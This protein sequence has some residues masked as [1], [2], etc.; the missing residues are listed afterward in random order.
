MAGIARE[1]RPFRIWDEGEKRDLP[2]RSYLTYER[3]VERALT[4]LV[5][6]PIG[7]SYTIYDSRNAR[8]LRQWKRVV[9]GLRE[10]A[11]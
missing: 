2:W 1:K 5:W 6:L 7:N 11:E 10:Y 3:A 9:D 4:L 8:A